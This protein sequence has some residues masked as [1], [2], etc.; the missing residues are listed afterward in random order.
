MQASYFGCI[1]LMLNLAQGDEKGCSI[2]TEDSLR[3]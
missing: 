1:F 2:S 3:N